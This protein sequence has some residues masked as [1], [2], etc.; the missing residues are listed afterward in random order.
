MVYIYIIYVFIHFFCTANISGDLSV[1]H[2]LFPPR[3]A[4]DAEAKLLQED[5]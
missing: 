5:P 1:R 2:S 3:F 4:M